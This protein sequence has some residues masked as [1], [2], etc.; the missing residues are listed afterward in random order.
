MVFARIDSTSTNLNLIAKPHIMQVS[1]IE[2]Y[3]RYVVDVEH[4]DTTY[5][6]HI[7]EDAIYDEH[8]ITNLDTADDI[9]QSDPLYKQ[10]LDAAYDAINAER[11]RI[12]TRDDLQEVLFRLSPNK[13]RTTQMLHRDVVAAYA[14]MQELM[15]RMNGK[16]S[17]V[18]KQDTNH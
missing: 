2:K 9:P 3:P 14:M 13:M 18:N 15:D 12:I 10:L 17:T 7:S 11:N 8:F 5:T 4:G 16:F 6:V 1:N